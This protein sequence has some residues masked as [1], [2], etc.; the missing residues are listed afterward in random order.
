L[1]YITFHKTESN[2]WAY[3]HEGNKKTTKLLGDPDS[4][5]KLDELRG[6]SFGPHGYLYVVNGDKKQNQVLVYSGSGDG[7]GAYSF[8]ERSLLRPPRIVLLLLLLI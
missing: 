7:G 8:I 6:I 3:D 5:I 4:P 1:F 2:V